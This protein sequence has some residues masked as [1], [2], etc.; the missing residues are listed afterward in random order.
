MRST[1]SRRSRSHAGGE[2]GRDRGV[3]AGAGR[4]GR[5]ARRARGH[6]G[7]CAARAPRR[8]RRHR[9]EP[10]RRDRVHGIR[11]DAAVHGPGGTGCRAEQRHPAA[12]AAVRGDEQRPPPEG[13]PQ[14][15][16]VDPDRRRQGPRRADT[17]C[18][19]DISDA[20]TG[21]LVALYTSTSTGSFDLDACPDAE[22]IAAGTYVLTTKHE[23]NDVSGAA[24]AR[25]GA[26]HSTTAPFSLVDGDDAHLVE[27][28]ANLD[29]QADARGPG[30]A[31]GPGPT[32][33][34]DWTASQPIQVA[35]R[36]ADRPRSRAANRR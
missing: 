24:N 16:D 15:D 23:L 32:S 14:L 30:T 33:P 1:R 9:R 4:R 26:G 12:P 22:G 17:V 7:R 8:G 18:D 3:G 21:S 28:R 10:V 11:A 29:L 20:A 25:S 34:F 19:D 31:G 6:R 5:G 2:R 13:R 35:I 36:Q 27:V